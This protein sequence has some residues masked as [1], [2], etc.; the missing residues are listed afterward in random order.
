MPRPRKPVELQTR[1]NKV[2]DYQKKK[3]EEDKKNG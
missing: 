1:H 3:L 2:V